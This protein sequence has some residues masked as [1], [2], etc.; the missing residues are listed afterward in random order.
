MTDKE[1]L[2]IFQNKENSTRDYWKYNQLK[3]EDK[4]RLFDLLLKK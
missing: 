2:T 4:S 3:P 1:L